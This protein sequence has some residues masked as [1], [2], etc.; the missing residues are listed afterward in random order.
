MRSLTRPYAVGWFF[1]LLGF[2]IGA[3][4]ALDAFVGARRF[5]AA[6]LFIPVATTWIGALP[7]AL[8]WTT[9]VIDQGQPVPGAFSGLPP[10]RLGRIALFILESRFRQHE[11]AREL[12]RPSPP[13][14]RFAFTLWLAAALGGVPGAVLGTYDAWRPETLIRAVAIGKAVPELTDG[15]G[16]AIRTRDNGA[17]IYVYGVEVREPN[18]EAWFR[19]SHDLWTAL[20]GGQVQGRT[21]PI[22]LETPLGEASVARS[23]HLA[24]LRYVEVNGV[25]DDFGARPLARYFVGFV[26]LSLIFAVASVG[27][28]RRDQDVIDSRVPAPDTR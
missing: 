6:A 24:V 20:G 7:L 28:W 27:F 16:S 19:E 25:R 15:P 22:T 17:P 13:F 23:G 14:W 2:T 12:V 9:E 5:A 26:V 4:V 18:S 10:T 21:A 1:L 8:V 11:N 3:A